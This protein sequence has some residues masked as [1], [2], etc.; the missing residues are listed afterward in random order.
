MKKMFIII[1]AIGIS[2]STQASENCF[3]LYMRSDK[4]DPGEFCIQYPNQIREGSIVEVALYGFTRTNKY[5][6]EKLAASIGASDTIYHG[7]FPIFT[8]FDIN[9]QGKLYSV[10]FRQF[11]GWNP[12]QFASVAVT[13]L[14]EGYVQSEIVR[15]SG[16]SMG[17]PN[18]THCK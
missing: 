2:G 14:N 15:S 17:N 6:I 9:G 1:A 18:C 16:G 3:G 10:H 13:N 4:S 12:P 8:T 5:L 7:R 11:A